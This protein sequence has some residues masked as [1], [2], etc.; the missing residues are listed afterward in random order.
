MKRLLLACAAFSAVS[1]CQLLYQA[2]V[3]ELMDLKMGG[4]SLSGTTMNAH[5]KVGNPN[6]WPVHC[7][8]VTYDLT[9]EGDKAGNGTYDKEFVIPAGDA[10]ELD[11]PLSVGWGAAL[12]G[13]KSA[14]GKGAVETT[15]KGII[16]LRAFFG[17]M[18]VPYEIRGRLAGEEKDD[19]PPMRQPPPGNEPPVKSY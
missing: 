8:K 7:V 2:P 16:T 10:I 9:V 12:G 11:F 13:L 17:D 19:K 1:G 4:V 18:Q 14:L 15:T 5:L 6:F 3:L